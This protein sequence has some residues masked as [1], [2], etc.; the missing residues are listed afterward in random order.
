[1]LLGESALSVGKVEVFPSTKYVPLSFQWPHWC[2]V[3][4]SAG[5]ESGRDL[6]TRPFHTMFGE[7]GVL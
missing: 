4:T 5:R 1:M 7:L 6:Q 3:T 2:Q